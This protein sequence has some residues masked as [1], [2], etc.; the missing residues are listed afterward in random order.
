MIELRATPEFE[1]WI[2]GLRDIE[3]RSRIQAR[4]T[5][6]WDGNPGDHKSVGE[7]VFEMRIHYG[8]GYRLYFTRQ[9]LRWVIILAG[10]DKDSQN[11]DIRLALRLARNL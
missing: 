9:G 11:R 10:G 3:A 4:I 2:D 6:L 8:P 1:R 5:R 7:G